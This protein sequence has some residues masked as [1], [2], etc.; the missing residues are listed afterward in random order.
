MNGYI[1]KQER[2]RIKAIAMGYEEGTP[3]FHRVVKQLH[4]KLIVGLTTTISKDAA[5]GK[6]TLNK[7]K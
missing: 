2:A 3:A 1:T 7:K 5:T 6:I 4:A